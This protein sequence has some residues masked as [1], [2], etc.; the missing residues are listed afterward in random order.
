M[1]YITASHVPTPS[2]VILNEDVAMWKLQ[3]N[4]WNVIGSHNK[5]EVEQKSA[6]A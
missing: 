3:R 5:M 6:P 1:W 2:L 4:V